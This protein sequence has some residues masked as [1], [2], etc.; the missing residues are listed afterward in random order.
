[1]EPKN[2]NEYLGN[3]SDQRTNPWKTAIDDTPG[4]T[5]EKLRELGQLPGL[6]YDKIWRVYNGD[7]PDLRSSDAIKVLIKLN[8][9]RTGKMDLIVPQAFFLSLSVRNIGHL[10]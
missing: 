10:M 4:N 5:S 6:S 3:Q 1:M 9:W 8:E 7:T 2:Q